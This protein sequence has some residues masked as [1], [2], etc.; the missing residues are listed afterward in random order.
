MEI[1]TYY[2][3]QLT[4]NVLATMQQMLAQVGIDVKPRAVDVP[5]YNQTLNSKNFTMMFAGLGNGPDPDP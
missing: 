4:T 1:L 5:T 3:D 2:G